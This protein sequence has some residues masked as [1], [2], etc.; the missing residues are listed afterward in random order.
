[1]SATKNMNTNFWS[2][3]AVGMIASPLATFFLFALAFT[4]SMSELRIAVLPIYA[5]L[6]LMCA[7]VI[8]LSPKNMLPGIITALSLPGLMLLY[9]G[10][11]SPEFFLHA[12]LL[13]SFVCA[14][15]YFSRKRTPTTRSER[16][17]N[18]WE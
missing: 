8:W 7:F 9:M 10:S 1:M 12:A 13:V 14:M 18:D 16:T 2:S 3:I 4:R 5:G 15:G 6:L 17:L 11:Q